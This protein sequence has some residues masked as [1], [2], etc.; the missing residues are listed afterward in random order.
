MNELEHSF[1]MSVSQLN[2]IIT[3]NT[4]ILLKYIFEEATKFTLFIT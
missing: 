1:K 4:A 3:T 2:Q